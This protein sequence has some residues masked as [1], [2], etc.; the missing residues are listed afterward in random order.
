LNNSMPTTQKAAMK[1]PIPD[2]FADINAKSPN[3][4][5][6]LPLATDDTALNRVSS[7]WSS[8]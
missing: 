8:V 2:Y 6:S 1:R 5:P 4:A 7:L 3:N